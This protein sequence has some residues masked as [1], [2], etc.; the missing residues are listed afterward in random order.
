MTTEE[1]AP[2]TK[3]ARLTVKDD[4]DKPV[5]EPLN[6]SDSERRP[7]DST[8]STASKIVPVSGSSTSSS[9]L[10]LLTHNDSHGQSSSTDHN[11]LSLSALPDKLSLW[12]R[13]NIEEL[14]IKVSFQPETSPFDL[15]TRPV[16]CTGG[17]GIRVTTYDVEKIK[18]R[19]EEKTKR[20]SLLTEFV[21]RSGFLDMI[22]NVNYSTFEELNIDSLLKLNSYKDHCF[23]PKGIPCEFEPWFR[24]Y[25]IKSHV[26]CFHN[27]YSH[28][29]Y[30]W[31]P[32]SFNSPEYII[33][34]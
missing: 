2:K 10:G 25:A 1:E 11:V 4:E 5:I 9:P 18:N 33:Y 16:P 29:G 28:V 13:K 20:I 32:V 12:T 34:L 3:R 31:S 26:L 23:L 21:K 27:Y 14:N 7:R 19:E 6:K 30:S 15:I 22:Q 8:T 24:R 17:I